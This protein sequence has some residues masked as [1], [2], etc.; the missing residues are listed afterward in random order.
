MPN[1]CRNF[2]TITGEPETIKLLVEKKLDFDFFV[3]TPNDLVDGD[4]LIQWRY[5]N[6]GTKWCPY[7]Y[8][9]KQIGVRG[10]RVAFYSA[11][12]PPFHFF[13]K[14][15]EKFPGIWIKCEWH[16]EGG[17]AGVWVGNKDEI[18]ELTWMD[19]CLEAEHYAFQN[20]EE[21]GSS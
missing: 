13:E 10:M 3:P 7:E 14:L 19:M 5:N 16:E 21:T 17:Y 4:A 12:N 6:W 9:E 8:Q 15:L 20:N 2:V 1:D 18:K 11:W